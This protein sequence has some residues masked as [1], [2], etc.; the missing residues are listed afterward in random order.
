MNREDHWLTCKVLLL[1]SPPLTWPL[2]SM[3]V[4]VPGL[5]ETHDSSC[6][7]S[8]QHLNVITTQLQAF[9][10]TDAITSANPTHYS[11][12]LSN[13]IMITSQHRYHSSTSISHHQSCHLSKP[14]P[15]QCANSTLPQ[16][17]TTVTSAY[18]THYRHTFC[19]HHYGPIPLNSPTNH[20]N[21]AP[22]HHLSH[23]LLLPSLRHTWL[24]SELLRELIFGRLCSWIII[25]FS[26][27][28][29]SSS[30]DNHKCVHFSSDSCPKSK[31]HTFTDPT[32]LL[33]CK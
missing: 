8:E 26:I 21:M 23:L 9:I 24:A 13:F 28:I 14:N 10:I 19:S 4:A 31:S 17:S 25:E 12:W 1:L 2:L 11:G 16:Q 32:C 7:N 3:T 15:L 29:I 6:T 18:P 33:L 30:A 5:E 20:A 22:S 27:I